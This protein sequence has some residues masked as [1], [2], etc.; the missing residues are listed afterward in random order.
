MQPSANAR[1]L[2]ELVE[3]HLETVRLR[4]EVDR[5]EFERRWLAGSASGRANCLPTAGRP[6]RI[7]LRCW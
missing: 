6:I 4:S 2:L 5:V 1:Q 7:N 3:L